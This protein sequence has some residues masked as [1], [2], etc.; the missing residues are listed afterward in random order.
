MSGAT[1]RTSTS[2]AAPQT[3]PA[4]R[5]RESVPLRASQRVQSG[6]PAPAP[7][8]RGEGSLLLTRAT[9]RQIAPPSLAGKGAG[10]L[11]LDRSIALRSA[12]CALPRPPNRQDPRA[13]PT[14]RGP[15]THP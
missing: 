14:P 5:S 1:E 7:P 11:G 13:S 8:L 9:T 6:T 12:P 3:G 4:A 15:S 2:G 10:G